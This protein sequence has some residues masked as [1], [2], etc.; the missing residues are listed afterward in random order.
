MIKAY[1]EEAEYEVITIDNPTQSL[2]YLFKHKPDLV[3]IDF[4]MP[5][6]NGN[7][8]CRIIKTSPLFKNTPLIMIS[9]NSKMLTPE[10]MKE[11]GAIDYLAKPFRK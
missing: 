8:L 3:L 2:T 5:G 1:L 9:G 10:N 4:S 7:K 6:I 11:A